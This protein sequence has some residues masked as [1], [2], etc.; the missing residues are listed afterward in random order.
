MKLNFSKLHI[1]T[2][3]L[4]KYITSYNINVFQDL[5]GQ[6]MVL[7]MKKEAKFIKLCHSWW[8]SVFSS[9]F[10]YCLSLKSF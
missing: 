8:F 6:Q 1:R 2:D 4:C 9:D 10:V 3:D 7:Q 5:F